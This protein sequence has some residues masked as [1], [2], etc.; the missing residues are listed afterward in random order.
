MT[1]KAIVF[2]ILLL[3]AVLVPATGRA[4]NPIS[5]TVTN[6]NFDRQYV[7]V[8]DDVCH[9]R[10]FEGAVGGNATITLNCCAHNRRYGNI[11]IWNRKTGITRRHS[12]L[13]SGASI[14][15]R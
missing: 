11:R 1:L 2:S 12:G 14:R 7:V 4:Q 6:S 5:F 10:L 8:Y 9:R 15:L 13:T 3:S